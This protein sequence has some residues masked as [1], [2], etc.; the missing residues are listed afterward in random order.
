M[1]GLGNKVGSRS[2]R[3]V[4]REVERRQRREMVGERETERDP[5]R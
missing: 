3:P 4:N 5:L 1:V 2:L